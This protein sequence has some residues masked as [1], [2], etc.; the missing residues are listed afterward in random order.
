MRSRRALAR[1]SAAA[2]ATER[3]L[4]EVGGRFASGWPARECC[5]SR[6][7]FWLGRRVTGVVRHGGTGVELRLRGRV[8]GRTARPGSSG[9]LRDLDHAFAAGPR[10]VMSTTLWEQ[11]RALGLAP[12]P[13]SRVE[14]WDL[15]RA[16]A[17]G[18]RCGMSTTLREQGRSLGRAPGCGSNDGFRDQ[19][20]MVVAEPASGV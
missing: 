17:A 9:G 11:G 1:G 5:G 16:L 7:A 3:S 19:H 20:H 8:L 2:G 10:C 13:G 12:C 15:D 6:A 14:L 18:P 4:I